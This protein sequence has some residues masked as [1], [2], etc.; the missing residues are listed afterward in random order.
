MLDWNTDLLSRYGGPG[1]RYT[2]YPTA[3]QFHEEI[4]QE[5]YLKA[6]QEA[7]DQRRPVALYV[8]IPFC[9][10]L[11]YY[12]ACNRI[13]TNNKARAETYLNYLF[14]EMDRVS[15][16][17]DLQRPVVQM[18]WGGGTPTFLSDAQ[19]TALVYQTGR[20]FNLLDDEQADYSIEVDPRTVDASRIGLLRGL[21]FN[22][23]SIGIQ[24]LD[25]KVQSAVNRIQ[26]PELISD[27]FAT[28][29]DYGY[30]SINADLIYGLPW[31]SEASLARTI[32]QVIALRPGRVSL[33]SYAH[34][35]ARFKTQRQI[36]DSTLPSAIEKIRMFARAG[37]LFE[38]AGYRL[39]GMDH[40][41]LPDDDL[42]V[43]QDNGSLH[44]NF[45]GY[46]LHADADTLGMGVSAISQI[47]SLY[48][49][50]HKTMALWESSI[51]EQQLPIERGYLL[52]TDDLIRR[53]LIMQL[54][55]HMAVSLEQLDMRW[56]INSQ[57]YFSEE[58]Q[59]LET[60]ANDGLVQM[61]TTDIHITDQGRL[62]A[63]AIAMLF[64]RAS[65]TAPARQR[66]SR[67]I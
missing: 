66:F 16:L 64:D 56:G 29:R 28:I 12:C 9:N 25:P 48:S 35:P 63:R 2:S 65:Q 26:S 49:Q 11:C 20:L 10:N 50:N 45:Q 67:I 33:Y 21:G 3:I 38:Q 1:P 36:P 27:L 37:G 57:M 6:M 52:S 40:F 14:R 19:M 5:D 60:L 8:H 42:A 58:L 41:A 13:I 31:Q 44:R 54:L 34:L 22:R 43:A 61:N 53:E 59:A 47:G 51:E 24:D 23:V 30:R 15:S 55:C 46:S 18:H 7:N 62:V 4:G 32:E 17:V 39:I